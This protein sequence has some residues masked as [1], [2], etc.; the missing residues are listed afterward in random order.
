[1]KTETF[2]AIRIGDYYLKGNG[3]R[4]YISRTK[5]VHKAGLLKTTKGIQSRIEYL[6]S[7][8]IH[9]EIYVV[10]IIHHGTIDEVI[11]REIL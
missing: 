9:G 6:K 7:K 4:S 2:Y 10:E 3:R 11:E 8:G 1:M 5:M